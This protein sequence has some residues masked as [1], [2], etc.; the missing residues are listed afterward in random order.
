MLIVGLTKNVCG[1]VVQLMINFSESE[2]DQ[3]LEPQTNFYCC[4]RSC[5]LTP[6]QG[7]IQEECDIKDAS[8]RFSFFWGGGGWLWGSTAWESCI[9]RW[10]PI[11]NKFTTLF[12]QQNSELEEHLNFGLSLT[13]ILLKNPFYKRTT[14]EKMLLKVQAALRH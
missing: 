9:M 10:K 6:V 8:L 1:L 11:Y 4:L 5:F 14:V 12:R 7:C 2:R 13:L 3:T